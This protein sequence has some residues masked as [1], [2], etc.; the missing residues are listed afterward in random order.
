MEKPVVIE[1]YNENWPNEYIEVKRKIMEI[2]RQ[3]AVAIEHI[4]STSVQG[5]GAK[6]VMCTTKNSLIEDFLEKVPGGQEHIICMCIIMEAKNG[7]TSYYFE[8]I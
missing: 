6:P 8:I 4:G 3:K 1:H 2:F 7:K 5:L